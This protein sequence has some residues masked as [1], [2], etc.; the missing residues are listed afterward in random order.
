VA[1]VAAICFAAQVAASCA[2]ALYIAANNNA[3]PGVMLLASCVASAFVT[4]MAMFVGALGA[5]S[6]PRPKAFALIGM[7]G[8]AVALGHLRR[9]IGESLVSLGFGLIMSHHGHDWSQVDALQLGITFL[10]NAAVFLPVCAATAMSILV[11]T[12]ALRAAEVTKRQQAGQ[13][14]TLVTAPGWKL[15]AAFVFFFPPQTMKRVF[16]PAFENMHT[17]WMRAENARDLRLSRWVRIRGHALILLAL[18]QFFF[19]ALGD[20]IKQLRGL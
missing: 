19:A 1:R 15:R 5:R 10:M 14:G 4:T 16:D 7:L 6:L 17:E 3:R 20:L 12:I 11:A 13:A 9:E 2:Y 8:V 18:V